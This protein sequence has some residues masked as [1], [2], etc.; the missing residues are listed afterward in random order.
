MLVLGLGN[1]I[2]GDD[3]VGLLVA[4]ALREELGG[5]VDVEESSASGMA[6]IELFADHD[7]VVVI[8]AIRTGRNPPGTIT[9]MTLAHVGPVAAPSLHQAGLPELAAV[10][11]RLGLRFPAETA[12]FAVEVLDPYTIGAPMTEPVARAV[13]EC[14]RHVRDRIDRWGRDESERREGADRARLPRRPSAR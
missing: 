2:A 12:V 9:E 7:R 4:R 13:A 10:S 8:D 5:V 3:A 11:E 6:L 1:E 14:A